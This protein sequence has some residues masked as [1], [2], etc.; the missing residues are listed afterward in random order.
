MEKIQL[1]KFV[2]EQTGVTGN[3]ASIILDVIF[4]GI[5]RG[6][7]NDGKSTITNFGTF[8][9]KRVKGRTARNPRSG[10]T[11]YVPDRTVVRFKPARKLKDFILGI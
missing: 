4:K 11:V 8:R 1:K 6:L 5:I 10:E 7:V 9:T 2:M 3:E